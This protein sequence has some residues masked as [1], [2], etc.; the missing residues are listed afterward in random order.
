MRKRSI[1]VGSTDVKRTNHYLFMQI[2]GF[3]RYYFGQ[4]IFHQQ[5][6][7]LK[8]NLQKSFKFGYWLLR[9]RQCNGCAGPA[10][11]CT[12][13]SV[14]QP[15]RYVWVCPSNVDWSIVTRLRDGMDSCFDLYE[16][17]QMIPN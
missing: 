16:R 3:L 10:S 15:L 1:L 17:M 5:S 12:C 6:D 2:F 11:I 13:G 7:G 4:V 14:W 9:E 8:V